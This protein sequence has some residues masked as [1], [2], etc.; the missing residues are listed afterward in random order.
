LLMQP[1]LNGDMFAD[2]NVRDD[3]VEGTERLDNTC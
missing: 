3:L 1:P 2:L